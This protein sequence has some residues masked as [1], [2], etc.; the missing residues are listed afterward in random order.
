MEQRK[1]LKQSISFDHR[2]AIFTLY[3]VGNVR[4]LVRITST[5][6][7]HLQSPNLGLKLDENN[8]NDVC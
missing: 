4:A 6:K 3:L 2:K 1:I 5:T 8:I 7:T